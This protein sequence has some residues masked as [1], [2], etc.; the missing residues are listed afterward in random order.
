MVAFERLAAAVERIAPDEV[1]GPAVE[2][3]CQHPPDARWDYGVT[4]GIDDWECRQ[5]GYRTIPRDVMVAP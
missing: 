3:E 1:D 5:C 4:G 2:A